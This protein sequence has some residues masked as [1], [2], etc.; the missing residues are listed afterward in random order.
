MKI[1]E[2]VNGKIHAKLKQ[3]LNSKAKSQTYQNKILKFFKSRTTDIFKIA[4]AAHSPLFKASKTVVRRPRIFFFAAVIQRPH[5]QNQAFKMVR[6]LT[7]YESKLITTWNDGRYLKQTRFL[8]TQV[9]SKT[10]KGNHH[11]L[12]LQKRPQTEFRG[13]GLGL[14]SVQ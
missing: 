1:D 13:Q 9:D 11:V 10:S 8:D 5:D 14:R 7:G 3:I 6:I 2:G 12:L 4:F